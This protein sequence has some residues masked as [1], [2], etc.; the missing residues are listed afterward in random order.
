M[1]GRNHSRQVNKPDDDDA[2]DTRHR[3]LQRR[4]EADPNTEHRLRLAN[5]ACEPPTLP[6]RWW[7]EL[8]ASGLLE[9]TRTTPS[10]ALAARSAL[11]AVGGWPR[12]ELFVA[13]RAERAGSAGRFPLPPPLTPPPLTPPPPIRGCPPLRP[14]ARLSV[15]GAAT[16]ASSWR[17]SRRARSLLFRARIKSYGLYSRSVNII[18]QYGV[19]RTT[20]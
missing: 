9:P 2:A 7:V 4:Q 14:L 19:Q 18:V 13:G 11:A 6:P 8:F 3:W 16:P 5:R 15:R 1:A 20:F 17:S 10:E 12:R